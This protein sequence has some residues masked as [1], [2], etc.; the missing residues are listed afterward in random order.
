MLEES[1]IEY[2]MIPVNIGRG[3]QFEPAFL[4]ISPN[5]RMPAIVD[6][7]VDGEPVPV[8][9]SG[10]I[11]FYLGEKTGQFMPSD[12]IGRKEVLEWL[13]WQVGGL[14]PGGGQL[15]HF[16]SY[17]ADEHAYAIQRFRDEYDR[18]LGVMNRRLAD[19]DFLA[20]D[21][22]IADMASW[23]WMISYKH[24]GQSLDHLPHVK[25][26]H[27]AMKA[28]PGASRGIDAGKELRVFGKPD[29]EVREVM[30]GQTAQSVAAAEA[31][32]KEGG[33]G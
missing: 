26:W 20:G 30:F 31:A 9:E 14:G 5:N 10:A 16:I 28:R 21:Y 29:D 32:A 23:P 19:R 13:F 15:N 33:E 12:P 27:Q 4:T 11:L 3:D 2:R 8:F 18:L 24:F 6:H 25:R 17:A 22:S 1:G 7:D